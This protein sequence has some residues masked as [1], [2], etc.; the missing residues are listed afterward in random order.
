M[1]NIPGATNALPGVFTD[2]ITQSRGVSIPGGTR[3]AAIIGEGVTEETLVITA[4]GGG[5]D[6]FNPSYTSITTGTDGRHFKLSQFPI[7]SNRTNL[8]KNGIRLN[9][10]EQAIDNN[11]FDYRYDYRIDISNGQIELQK[12]HLVDQGGSNYLP[13]STNVGD[14][15]LNALALSDVNAPPETWNIRCVGVQRD[16]GGNPV[17]GTAK[18]IAIGSVSGQV[19]DSFGNPIFWVANGVQVTNGILTFAIFETPSFPVVPFKEGDTFIVKIASGVLVKGDYLTANY[20][21]T[22]VLNDPVLL[23]N[24]NDVV[25]RH[26]LP[27]LDNTLSLGSQLAFS[28]AAPALVTVQAAPAMPRRTSYT[29]SQSVNYYSSNNDDHIFP[30]PLGVVPDS[31]S[32][33]HFFVTNN[34]NNTESQVLPNKV[35]FNTV[36]PGNY[37]NFITSTTPPYAYAYTVVSNKATIATGFDG[38]VGKISPTQGLFSS[39][40]TFDSSYK[41]GKLLKIIDSAYPSNNGTFPITNVIDGKLYF[42]LNFNNFTSELFVSFN[43]I[44]STGAVVAGFSASDGSLTDL[45]SATATFSSGSINFNTLP[46]AATNY[47]LKIVGSPNNDGLFDITSY[48]VGTNE[49]TIIKSIVVESS[50]RYEVID[51]FIASNYVIVNRDVIPDSYGLRIT[52]VDEKDASFYDA[53]WLNALESLEKIE[54][55]MLVPLPKQTISAVF[56][57]ALAHCKSMSNI[58]NKKERVLL[59][60]AINGLTPDNLTGA[61]DAAV[62]DIGVL[63]GIQG[64]NIA[65]ISDV[66]IEDLADY[67]VPNAYGNTYRCVYFYPDQIVT[68]AGAENVF[69]DGFYIA[70]AA[71]GYLSGDLNI[72]NPLTN[73]V[74]TGFSILRNKQFSTVTLENLA[75][76]GVCVLQPVSGGGRVV[77]GITTSQSGYPEEQEI[78]IVFIRDRV[79]KILRAGFAGFIGT[80]ETPDT[81]AILN[82]RAVILLNSIASQGLITN[83]TDLVVARDDADPRQWNISVRVQPTYPVNFIYIKVGIGRI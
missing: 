29:L 49:L 16:S 12:A 50:L 79:A 14:G 5:K 10:L 72:Q 43:I 48:N 80:A 3:I 44:D 33:I 6:G 76:A 68:Q 25:N 18:F 58:K 1:P 17:P 65:E 73:K 26:G 60:G 37:T 63:E 15:Y 9:G 69:L 35:E 22:A 24:M 83:Y 11:Q 34:S 47:K 77:W 57:N 13:L 7:I 45:G 66:N 8:Y 71:A 40:I 61:E 28:N 21:P 64:D 2:V 70:A 42:T 56:Q 30:L 67:S 41:T 39:S 55:D 62:E 4:N 82:T 23:Q 20:I 31:N 27:S 59:I 52:I 36:N 32:N 74:L 19:L 75:A 81:Q 53:G 38:Y 78:S 54:C 51:P 46:L